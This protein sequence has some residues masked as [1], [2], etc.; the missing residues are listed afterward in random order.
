MTIFLVPFMSCTAK[1]PIYGV[2]SMAFFPRHA[3][4]VMVSL[5]LLGMLLAIMTGLIMKSSIFKGKPVPFVMELPNYR[6]PSFKSVVML[7]WDKAKDFVT[8]AFTII[9]IASLVIWFLQTFDLRMN[10]VADPSGSMLASIAQF[11]APIFTPL[12][13]GNWQSVT[14][15]LTGFMA[16]EAVVSTFAVLTGTGMSGLSAALQQLFTPASAYAFLVFT[17]L[18]TPCVAAVAA[19]RR[20]L[21]SR[22]LAIFAVIYQTSFA[23]VMSFVVYL[24][25][26]L[27]I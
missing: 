16:K 7:L 19:I 9:F 22:W 5:Y 27:F 18:Y 25:G 10:L 8:R 23:W 17:L 24:T 1:L 3:G 6:L 20:E 2:F 4:L 14:A 21:N 15:L 26:Q 12:G 11:I 13:F